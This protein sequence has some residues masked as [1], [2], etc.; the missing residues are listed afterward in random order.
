MNSWMQ[1]RHNGHCLLVNTNLSVWF[2]EFARGHLTLL[3]IKVVEKR[4][5]F[6]VAHFRIFPP[7]FRFLKCVICLFCSPNDQISIGY[8]AFRLYTINDSHL[9][10][11]FS[12]PNA[13]VS[14]YINWIDQELNSRCLKSLIL[15]CATH[16]SE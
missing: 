12:M 14:H 8:F 13:W 16:V 15:Y 9:W 1:W 7:I 6:V 5:H 11:N 2:N 3:T 10:R 4:L